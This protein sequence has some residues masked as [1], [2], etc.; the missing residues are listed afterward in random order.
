MALGARIKDRLTEIGWDQVDLLAAV[1]DLNAGTLSALITRDSEKSRFSEAIAEALGVSHRWLLEGVQPKSR[2]AGSIDRGVASADSGLPAVVDA[3]ATPNRLKRRA[4]GAPNVEPAPDI[5]PGG[6]PLI[7]WV[8]AGDFCEAVDNFVPGDSDERFYTTHAHG[9]SS[10]ALRVRG[11]SMLNPA[12]EDSF[13]EGDV[14][15]VDPDREPRH[16]SLVIV[17]LPDENEA[18]F[19]QLLIDGSRRYLQA[20]NPQWPNRVIELPQ[21]A[22][23]CGVVFALD[24]RYA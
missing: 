2:G 23:I 14:I 4:L 6:I 16:R 8:Q 18:T 9:R 22:T 24:R 19:K 7:S 17:R 13:R 3:A 21:D 15:L 11:D 5:R 1:P 20:L 12:G 10:Y